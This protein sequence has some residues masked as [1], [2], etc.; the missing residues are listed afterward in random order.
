VKTKQARHLNFVFIIILI[1]VHCDTTEPPGNKASLTLTLEDVSCTEAWLTLKTTDIPLPTSVV[2]KQNDIARTT[3][4]LS[5]ADTLLYIDSLLPQQTYTYQ[6]SGV[7]N[8]VSSNKITATTLDTTSHN[9]TWQTFT[10]G[11]HSSSVLYDVAIINENNIWAVGEIYMNDS[12]GQPDSKR[13]NLV[14]WNGTKWEVKRVPYN[15]QGST[16]YHPIQAV[17]VFSA[18]NIWLCG[19]GVIRWNGQQFAEVPIPTSVWGPY[20]MNKLWG[21]SSDDLYVV[22]NGGNIA[23]YNG[24]SWTK[25][26]SGTTVDLMDVGGSPD[27]SIVWA[28]GY[29]DDKPGTYLL[30]STGGNFEMA[31]D[32]TA[33]EIKILND[34]ISGAMVS[35]FTPSSKKIFVGTTTGVY[36]APSTTNGK[37][38]RLSFTDG[39]FPGL[40]FRLRGNGITDFMIVG[41]YSFIAHYNGFGWRYFE[42]LW[43]DN[44]RFRSVSQKNN[45]S[46]VVGDQYISPIYGPAVIYMGRR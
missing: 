21:S 3:I 44:I 6:V 7:G 4:N 41:E 28:C 18:D 24:T 25:I 26:E 15:Y 2:L 10:F 5:T 22:G 34:T 20:Q 33:N 45:I 12:V 37:G 8:Q 27:G 13:Y 38:K 42:E 9:F 29:Y 40:P 19:N 32:G 11:Q 14:V 17:Y 30:R 16:F 23:H 39:Y 43:T 36:S 1:F 31:Y 46:V 35:V